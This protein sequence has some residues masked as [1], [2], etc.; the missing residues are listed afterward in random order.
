M[1]FI[2]CASYYGTGSSAVTDLLSEYEGV[3]SFTDEEIRFLHDPDGVDDL[4]YHIVENPNRH[5]S[6]HAIKR[7]KRLVDFYSGSWW[8]GKKYSKLF[9]DNWKRASYE[10]IDS[11]VDFSYKGGWFYDLYDKG[12]PYYF[13][14]RAPQRVFSSLPLIKKIAP[15]HPYKGEI[16]YCTTCNEDEFV[17]KTKSYIETLFSQV[18]PKEYDTVMVDQLLPSSNIQRYTR[19]FDDVKVVVVER[20]P[21]DVWMCERYVWKEGVIPSDSVEAYCRWFEYSRMKRNDEDVDN[22]V[23]TMLIHFEDLVFDYYNTVSKLEKW[24]GL[25]PHSHRNEMKYFD[26]SRSINN[27]RIWKRYPAERENVEYI[28]KRLSK[29][30][31]SFPE[32]NPD[33]IHVTDDRLF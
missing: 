31:Y 20:D 16:T 17:S 8:Y 6:G 33:Y 10:Y 18:I 26:P 32:K 11:L 22:G 5:N 4:Y 24:L 2:S 23:T 14:K 27:T 19:Y 28:E 9:G 12:M 3:Y 7:F 13:I 29:Y 15:T 25:G 21:R 1:K 30:I